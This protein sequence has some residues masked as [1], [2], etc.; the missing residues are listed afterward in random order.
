[1]RI[2]IISDAGAPQVNG[3]VHTLSATQRC[4]REA[5]HNVLMVEPRDFHTFACPTYPEI[6]L[7]YQPYRKISALLTAFQPDCIHIATEGPLGLAARRYCLRH[8]LDFTTAYHTRFPEYLSARKLLPQALTYRLLRWFHGRSKAVMAPSP[9]IKTALEAQ[10]FRNVALWSRGVDADCFK[11]DVEDRACIERPLFLYVGRVAREKNIE[12]FLKL[13]LPGN[14]WVIG[15]GPMRA[16]LESRYPQVRFL[17]AKSHDQLSVYYNCADVFVFPSRTDTFGLVLVEAMACGVPV[18]AYPV[19]GP[20]DVVAN[21]VSGILDEDLGKACHEA[22]KLDRE[23]TREHALTFS[24]E[25]ATQQFLEHL[26]PAR[27][28]MA[29]AGMLPA[30]R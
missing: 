12:A 22:L 8:G 27:P 19:P 11:P 14:K 18:A 23:R 29:D 5:G 13:D 24:W 15:D 4:L 25:A 7:A 30:P 26:H 16:E 1:M 21:G 10:G 6:R 9:A 17:G 20:L 28:M 2:A 3:V